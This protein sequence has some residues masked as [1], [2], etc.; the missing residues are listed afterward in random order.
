MILALTFLAGLCA[1][2]RHGLRWRVAGHSLAGVA[3]VAVVVLGAT[4][5]GALD[6]A[7]PARR[8]LTLADKL[9]QADAGRLVLAP[10]WGIVD[11]AHGRAT[12]HHFALARA[13]LLDPRT[14]PE[15]L[16]LASRGQ[17]VTGGRWTTAHAYRLVDPSQLSPGQIDDAAR[18]VALQAALDLERDQETAGFLT[19]LQMT[20]WQFDD[21]P[22]AVWA[23]VATPEPLEHARPHLEA[24][25]ARLVATEVREPALPAAA[26]AAEIGAFASIREA[27]RLWTEDAAPRPPARTTR[28]AST[29]LEILRSAS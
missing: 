1:A 20:A 23:L 10:R 16:I 11:L 15:P 21:V 6:G 17:T 28:L 25:G 18:A 14:R 8:A 27:R 3:T 12:R 29:L 24:D 7:G 19:G 13:H 4:A 2:R 9:T 22:A 5:F 26:N